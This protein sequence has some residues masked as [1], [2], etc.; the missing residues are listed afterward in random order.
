[1]THSSFLW[2]KKFWFQP[3]IHDILWSISS[4]PWSNTLWF[5]PHIHHTIISEVGI[6]KR[7]I[8]RKKKENKLSI[9]KKVTLKEKRKKYTFLFEKKVRVKKKRYWSRKRK[10]GNWKHKFSLIFYISFVSTSKSNWIL[11]YRSIQQMIENYYK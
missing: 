5:T 8:L 10:E 6:N 9:M 2:W 1:M 11:S 7:K 3:H 4:C